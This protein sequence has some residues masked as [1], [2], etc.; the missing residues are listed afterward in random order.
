LRHGTKTIQEVLK[1]KSRCLIV[2]WKY[3]LVAELKDDANM[4]PLNVVGL[5]TYSTRIRS[6]LSYVSFFES[7]WTLSQMH[8]ESVNELAYTKGYLKKVL[9]EMDTNKK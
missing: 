2:D 7:Y 6:V 3:S 9:T 5:S 8:E 4:D 1:P